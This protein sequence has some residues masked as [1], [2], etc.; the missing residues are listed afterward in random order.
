MVDE[1]EVVDDELED[2]DELDDVDVLSIGGVEVVVVMRSARLGSGSPR[3]PSGLT[4]ARS[5]QNSGIGL[6]NCM[7]GDPLSAELMNFCQIVAG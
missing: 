5:G 6:V 3:P 2:V 1:V 4:G 7:T